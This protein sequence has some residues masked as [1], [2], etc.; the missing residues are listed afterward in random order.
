[1]ASF[2][3]ECNP[4]ILTEI[5]T[6]NILQK[7][8]PIQIIC[9]LSILTDKIITTNSCSSEVSLKNVQ[10]DP[11]IINAIKYVENR[12]SEYIDL[13]NRMGQYSE[14]GYWDISYDYLELSYLWAR[15]NILTEDHSRILTKL[16]DMGEYEGSFIK[17]MLKINSIV[18]NLVLLCGLTQ[19]LELVPVLQEIEPLILKGMVNVDSLHVL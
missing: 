12:V 17:N 18:T 19:N 11:I 6:G 3:N 16:Y 2:V 10:I 4:F 7:M 5:F 9:F 13:E 14:P 1:M 8:Q 15:M